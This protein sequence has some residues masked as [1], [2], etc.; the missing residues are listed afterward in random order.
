MTAGFQ[1]G[2]QREQPLDVAAAQRAGR[3]VEHQHAAADGNRSRN[4]HELLIGH[5]QIAG[6][7]I[8]RDVGASE[9][10]ERAGRNPV[11]GR[12]LNDAEARRFHAE[13]NVVGHA[14]VGRERQLLVNHRD[15]GAPGS[16]RVARGVGLP[17]EEHLPCVRLD[18]AGQDRH[19]RA[20]AG[21][22]LAHQAAH[23]AW[24]HGEVDACQRDG[25]IEP[26][27]DAAHLEAAAHFFR[28]G[29][30]SC[31]MSGRSRMSRVT[32]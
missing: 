18:R 30:T 28:S 11:H 2:N 26:L 21:A 4:F 5:R 27:L 23:F 1:A 6:Q 25:G 10:R 14:Q 24:R 31:L 9:F 22:V 20:L 8:R 7:P 16:H 29:C 13:E 32:R 3:L 17:V 19:Q 12:A 15:A